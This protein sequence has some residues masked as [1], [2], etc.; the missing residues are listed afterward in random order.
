M[1]NE[2]S[3]FDDHNVEIVSVY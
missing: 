3:N 2:Y 1:N